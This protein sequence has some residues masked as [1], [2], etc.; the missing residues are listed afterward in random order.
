MKRSRV[1]GWRRLAVCLL[2]VLAGAVTAGRE[3]QANPAQA[4]QF[5]S[6]FSGRWS[7]SGTVKLQGDRQE[8]ISCRATYSAAGA[9]TVVQTLRCANPRYS[10]NFRSSM[11]LNGARVSGQWQD[12]AHGRSGILSGS[13]RSKAVALTI[14]GAGFSASMY[15][16]VDACNQSISVR[17]RGN[18]I[19]Q[20]AVRLRKG[21]C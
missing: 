4:R 3:T 15:M 10:F 2:L 19:V 16:R 17:P 14:S 9:T 12:D 20:V 21:G 7:G 11:R 13:L 18:E 1:L 6:D 5:V 8:R